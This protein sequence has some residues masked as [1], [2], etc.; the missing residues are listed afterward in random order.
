MARRS[1]AGV[2]SDAVADIEAAWDA[3]ARAATRSR[4]HRRLVA[5]AG[6]DLDRAGW[7]L[8]RQLAASGCELRATDLAEL[9]DIDLPWV[10]R[11]VQQLERAGLVSRSVDDEDRR[12]SRLALTSRGHEVLDRLLLARRAQLSE[13]LEDWNDRALATFAELLRRF[14]DDI[15]AEPERSSGGR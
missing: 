15:A 14:A 5:R 11:K 12:A 1:P 13:I 3:V 4:A 2:D 10:T 7:A 9:L 6:V 8:L